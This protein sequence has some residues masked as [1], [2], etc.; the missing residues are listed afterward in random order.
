MKEAKFRWHLEADHE[1]FVNKTLDVF[2]E[3]EHQVKRS[4]IDRPAAWGIVAYFRNKAVRVFFF[5]SWK[6]AQEKAPHTAGENLIKPAAVEMARILC[7]D[8]V[9]NKLAMI[10]LSNDTIKRRIQEIS[11]D[12][13]QQII[14]SVK[15]SGKFSLQL[16]ETTD[17]G[18][19][20]QLMVFVQYLDKNNYMEQFLF[21][22][23]LAKNTTGEQIF[24]KVDLFF[25]KHQLE[26]SDCVSVCED[27]MM[28]QK[29][30]S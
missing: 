19:D 20:A 18:N 4:R 1:K 21:C 25:K 12:A 30:A 15:R 14:A 6:I 5:V 3:K 27:D 11:E 7:G 26:W 28:G 2:K 9:A 17:I 13:L 10:P 8:V 16:D 29:K 23:P 24:K 22:P